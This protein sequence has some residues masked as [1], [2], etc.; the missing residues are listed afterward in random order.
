LVGCVVLFRICLESRG[1]EKERSAKCTMAADFFLKLWFIL[2]LSCVQQALG[3]HICCCVWV[4]TNQQLFEPKFL[5]LF[6]EGLKC[7]QCD[8]SIDDY[9]PES[10][11]RYD[12]E[13]T[14]CGYVDYPAFCVKTTGIYGAIVGTRRFCSSRHMDNSCNEVN[15]P[16][17][18]R[19]YYSCIYTCTR[20]GCNKSSGRLFLRIYTLYLAIFTSLLFLTRINVYLL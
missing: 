18:P 20:D 16:Q 1:A 10:W 4:C 5:L 12:L 11:D 7:Y 17:D 19:T 6:Y 3:K 15:F 2:G 9:C 14:D 13:P 8:S